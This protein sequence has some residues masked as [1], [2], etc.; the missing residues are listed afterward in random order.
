MTTLQSFELATVLLLAGIILLG[1]YVDQ[2]RARRRAQKFLLEAYLAKA[3]AERRA[4][5]P[6]PTQVL[7]EVFDLDG[8][9]L[10]DIGAHGAKAPKHPAASS[11]A[12]RRKMGAGA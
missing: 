1:V 2:L 6:I 12:R 10:R 3:L 4:T 9:T 5:A 11:P 8:R 7:A